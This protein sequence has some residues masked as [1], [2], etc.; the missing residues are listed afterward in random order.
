MTLD[1]AINAEI[2]ARVKEAEVLR[3]N[4]ARLFPVI[5]DS[6][7]AVRERLRKHARVAA[8][9]IIPTENFTLGTATQCRIGFTIHD[10][11]I[12][13][14]TEPVPMVLPI[15]SVNDYVDN[16]LSAILATYPEVSL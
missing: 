2:A 9:H 14:V 6:L 1:E 13:R 15:T 10:D 3:Y 11:L 8:I 16:I 12:F 5:D 7:D 4:M